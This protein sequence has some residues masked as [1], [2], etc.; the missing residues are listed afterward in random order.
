MFLIERAL[1]RVTVAAF[2][3]GPIPVFPPM[4]V[5]G[6]MQ[7]LGFQLNASSSVDF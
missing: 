1:P 3:H 5:F 2:S 6:V 4:G 7:N